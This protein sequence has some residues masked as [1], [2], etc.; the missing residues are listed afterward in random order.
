MC[1]CFCYQVFPESTVFNDV[2]C[3]VSTITKSASVGETV[4]VD[5]PS[6]GTLSAV[7]PISPTNQS[8]GDCECSLC[9]DDDCR[10]ESCH[11]INDSIYTITLNSDGPDYKLCFHDISIEMNSTYVH[12]YSDRIR[13]DIFPNVHGTIIQI[14]GIYRL[15]IASYWII[16]K[17]N[18]PYCCIR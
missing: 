16:I 17:G 8:L 3:A 15:Y 1:M 13:C 11:C 18:Y 5:V 6:S 4:C 12:I 7:W 2:I 10:L 14:P 9:D